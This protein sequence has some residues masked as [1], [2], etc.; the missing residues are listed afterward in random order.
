MWRAARAEFE[1]AYAIDPQP[2]LL[3][4]IASTYRREGDMVNARL[5]YQRYLDT[6]DT[7]EAPL[8]RK[9]IA[10]IDAGL[11]A[12]TPA[13][14]ARPA[15]A[16]APPPRSYPRAAIER[17]LTLPH[18]VASAVAGA[19]LAAGSAVAPSGAIE[20]RYV[21]VAV[22][23]GAY[24]ITSRVEAGGE[25][26]AEI[27]GRPLLRGD[28][29]VRLHDDV[30]LRG[31]LSLT[32]DHAQLFDARVA[33]PL[34]IPFAGRLALVSNEDALVVTFDGTR[35]QTVL[36][37]PI[38]LGYQ[39]TSIVYVTATTRA[40]EIEL[41]DGVTRAFPER[42]AVTATIV[43]TQALDLLAQLRVLAD[44]VDGGLFVRVRI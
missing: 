40:F 23:G 10:E 22:L 31:S 7:G 13:L 30:A 9:T 27:G 33:V 4:N 11:L 20:T 39:L 41:R 38:G 34:R 3:F 26:A 6:G 12:P 18:G 14:V 36:R 21:P 42:L 35:D 15:P 17:P 25:L 28:L 24:G 5:Y 16:V 19:T 2:I 29:A 43:P 37:V 44:H 1:A 32:L 8:A